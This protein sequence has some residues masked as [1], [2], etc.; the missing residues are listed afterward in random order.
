MKVSYQNFIKIPFSEKECHCRYRNYFGNQ[1]GALN[2]F[3]YSY[4]PLF[5]FW[6][7]QLPCLKCIWLINIF[8]YLS[9]N[10]F[11][12]HDFIVT[13]SQLSLSNT[14]LTLAKKCNSEHLFYLFLIFCMILGEFAIK[15]KNFSS[16]KAQT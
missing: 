6:N 4:T 14:A 1:V 11:Q 5:I 8:P 16:T 15:L 12:T 10:L 9:S 3:L 7:E 13:N 2:V